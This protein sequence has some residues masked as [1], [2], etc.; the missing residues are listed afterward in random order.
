MIYGRHSM[1]RG[2]YADIAGDVTYGENW[3][4]MC[5]QAEPWKKLDA[6]QSTLAD[7]CSLIFDP[8]IPPYIPPALIA[9]WAG[10]RIPSVAQDSTFQVTSATLKLTSQGNWIGFASIDIFG[11]LEPQPV[12]FDAANTV[13]SRPLTI[14][15]TSWAAP[16][17]TDAVQYSVDVTAIVREILAQA[18]RVSGDPVAFILQGIAGRREFVAGTSP[19]L[20]IVGA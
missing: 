9:T 14:S 3:L 1:G 5:A 13:K 20:E 16:E 12:E 2:T 17:M 4:L 10:I 7:P 15:G 11:D 8:V 6:P 18:A 19:V